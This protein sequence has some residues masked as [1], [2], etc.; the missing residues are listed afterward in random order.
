MLGRQGPGCVSPCPPVE[1]IRIIVARIGWPAV[2]L[3]AMMPAGIPMVMEHRTV[4]GDR[5][6]ICRPAATAPPLG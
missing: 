4:N 2:A 1:Q 3:V 5:H 6:L